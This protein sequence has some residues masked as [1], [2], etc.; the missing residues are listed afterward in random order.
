MYKKRTVAVVIPAYNEETLLSRVITIIPKFV[1]FLVI[2][3]D[4]SSDNTREVSFNYKKIEPD[5]IV[6]IH[7]EKNTGVGG[8]IAD[9]YEWCR[10]NDIDFA[11]V[12]AGDAQMDPSELKD[13]IE[14]VDKD[15]ADYTKGNRLF[16]GDA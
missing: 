10:D 13:L 16:T 3:D 4:A 6:I 2:I 11:A 8:S 1:D 14:P 7:H 5:R 9:G 12:M 15:E